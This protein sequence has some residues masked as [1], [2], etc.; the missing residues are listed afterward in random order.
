M[1]FRDTIS[2]AGGLGLKEEARALE[3]R[4]EHVKA[5]FRS[6]FS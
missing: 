5:V 4:L 6:Q 1:K 3:Q 2:A